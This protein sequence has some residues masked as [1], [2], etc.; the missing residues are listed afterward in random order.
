MSPEIVKVGWH[1]YNTNYILY[2]LFSYGYPQ[3]APN[4]MR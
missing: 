1:R 3:S 4:A 2:S